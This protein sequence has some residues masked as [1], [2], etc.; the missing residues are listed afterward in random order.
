MATPSDI[1]RVLRARSDGFVSGQALS[2]ELRI[3][4]TAVWKHVKALR[5]AGYE[6]ES[7]PKLGYRFVAAPDALLPTEIVEGLTT[8]YLGRQA[9]LYFRSCPSTNDAARE[10]G[11]RGAP[12]GSLA[13][14]EGQTKGR[15]RLGR[16]WVSP[17]GKGIY[18]SVLLR[19]RIVPEEAFKLTLLTAVA[20]AQAVT[21][22]G[23]EAKIRW[24]NDVLIGGR[25]VAGILT[26]LEAEADRIHQ[27]VIG[28]G[29]NV[30]TPASLFPRSLRGTATS[31]KLATGQKH[32]RVRVL[33]EM[34]AALEER[35]ERLKAGRFEEVLQEWRSLDVTLGSRVRAVLLEGEIEGEAKD[36][37]S[38]GALLIVGAG[39]ALHRVSAGDIHIL[40]PAS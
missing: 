19:P 8:S 14:A 32:S 30:N 38:D 27:A 4:R 21:A 36:I 26:E 12:E 11:H 9:I 37:D 2:V 20:C 35:Y 10:L 5:A 6:V 39:G 7:R 15:G 24:P 22:A 28:I 3:T 25:K 29:L 18:V 34:L 40:R 23:A 16:G 31:L 13:V 17:A 33:Q 1:L